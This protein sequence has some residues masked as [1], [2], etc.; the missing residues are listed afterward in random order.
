MKDKQT[1]KSF[2]CNRKDCNLSI[3]YYSKIH[4]DLCSNC[5]EEL[6]QSGIGTSINAFMKKPPQKN[7]LEARRFFHKEFKH[8]NWK[9]H[10][11][12]R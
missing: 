3:R 6:I 10:I 2:M 7:N 11:N 4:G 9:K 8:I 5:F 1:E 12:W